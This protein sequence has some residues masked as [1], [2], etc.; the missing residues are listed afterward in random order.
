MIESATD[1]WLSLAVHPC[2]WDPTFLL[3][4][5]WLVHW[6]LATTLSADG[7]EGSLIHEGDARLQLVL[8]T[9]T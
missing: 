1:N 8:L 5:Q 4:W 2:S 7:S 9:Q 3:L 6:S